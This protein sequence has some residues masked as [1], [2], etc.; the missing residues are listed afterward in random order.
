MFELFVKYK[1]RS[2]LN[3]KVSISTVRLGSSI[4]VGEV[5]G[6]SYPRRCRPGSLGTSAATVT[7]SWLCDSIATGYRGPGVR[8]QW[9]LYGRR[10]WACGPSGLRSSCVCECVRTAS[11]VWAC[12]SVCGWVWV[13]MCRLISL[14]RVDGH[15]VQ[16]RRNVLRATVR[17]RA[18]HVCVSIGGL[19]G[20]RCSGVSVCGG[21]DGGW[22]RCICETDGG[23]P[24]K[25][26]GS[27]TTREY[28]SN[29]ERENDI[30][31]INVL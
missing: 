19:K 29:A 18:I 7:A 4:G 26:S 25:R 9:N 13:M 21:N 16:D 6:N 8:T 10:R 15:R 12:V 5:I 14:L 23:R 2:C 27:E 1:F 28:V 30:I 20:D 24:R 17:T 22:R 31:I 11:D 3:L